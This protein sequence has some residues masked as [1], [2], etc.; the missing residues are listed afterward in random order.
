ME[1]AAFAHVARLAGVP[2]GE[3]RGIS[4]PVGNRDR[5]AWRVRDAAKAAQMAL[6]D[7]W[8]AGLLV[9]AG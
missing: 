2:V 6:L 5:A 7:T 8:R 9:F 3:V 1:G 4:N